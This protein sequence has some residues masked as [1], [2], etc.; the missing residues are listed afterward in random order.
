MFAHDSLAKIYCDDSPIMNCQLQQKN[1]QTNL[2]HK[3]TS[4]K[5]SGKMVEDEV[6]AKH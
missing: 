6:V 1:F 3:C 4:E 2:N 5:T